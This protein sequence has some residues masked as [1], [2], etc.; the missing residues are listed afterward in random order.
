MRKK[1]VEE[2]KKKKK[3]H[4]LFFFAILFACM[5]YLQLLSTLAARASTKIFLRICAREKAI[6]RM[7]KRMEKKI[8]ERSTS[9]FL[10]LFFP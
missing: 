4:L 5:P 10:Y 7:R 3:K 6:R 8:L 9:V 1:K 2:G